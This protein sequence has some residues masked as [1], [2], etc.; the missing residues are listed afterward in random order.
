MAHR[1]ASL[2]HKKVVIIEDER[3]MLHAL[4]EKFANERFDV[5]PVS[6]GENG[7]PIALKIKPDLV[8]ID[9]FLPGMDGIEIL[10]RIRK[11][12]QWGKKVPVL[13][14]TNINPT[15]EILKEMQDDTPSG[16]LVK[17]NYKLEAVVKKAKELLGIIPPLTANPEL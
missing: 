1:T 13:F 11:A 8:M 14:L 5:I 4:A 9:I 12:N 17:S 15:T 16:Y 3:Q 10:K 7:L 2:Q 6:N